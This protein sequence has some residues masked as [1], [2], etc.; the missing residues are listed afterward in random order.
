MAVTTLSITPTLNNVNSLIQVRDTTDYAGQGVPLDGSYY[1]RGYLRVDV[2]SASGSQVV[3]DNIDGATPDIDPNVS[4]INTST[5]N[6]PQDSAGNILNGTYTFTY[7]MNIS[8]DSGTNYDVTLTVSYDYDMSL[9]EACLTVS[10]NC[11]A[12]LLMSFDETDYGSYVSSLSRS[13]TLY[14]PPALNLPAI[15]GSQAALQAG[16]NI[17]DNTWTQ[18]ISTTA[19]YTFPDGL[20]AILL[21]EG[22]REF[23]VNCDIG[24]GKIFCCLDKLEKRYD[25]LTT[26]NPTKAA[27]MYEETVKP[28]QEAMLFY[29]SS[30]D[31]G[32]TSRAAYWYNQIIERSGC[33]EDCG[34]SADGPQQIYPL[35]ASANSFV[36]DSPDFSIQV[37]P[38]VT[39]STTTYHIQVSSAIQ[40]LINNMF[41]TTVSTATPSDIQ[42]V[43]SGT[44]PTRNYQI[45]YIGSSASNLC[46]C[47]KQFMIDPATVGVSPYLT[48]TQ[49]DVLNV[50]SRINVVGSQA[51]VL[52]TSS[53]NASTDP[54][55][56]LI[57]GVLVDPTQAAVITA[58]VMRTNDSVT[59]TNIANLKAEVF[60]RD[61]TTGRII[62]R[63]YN[64][65]TGQPYTLS[66][67]TTGTFDKIYITFNVI[68]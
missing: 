55:V 40:A 32:D 51:V 27:E 41:S 61:Y 36:V 22:S 65:L 10:I 57:D 8:N 11:Q 23:G 14:P 44:T 30:L 35:N 34:C 21:I 1:L 25:R 68:A 53:P 5:I 46:F 6:L 28:T 2:T 31:C 39:G 17:Y 4:D 48:F 66:D 64:P 67:L 52:G 47:S 59:Y 20:I 29:K 58:E 43:Q 12:S 56:F 38:E 18:A 60:H 54:A 3:Y 37:V 50:G 13:H 62:V 63:L 7:L 9:P 26:Q 33:G 19:T 49:S 15:T 24:L 42:I 16:P 45:N